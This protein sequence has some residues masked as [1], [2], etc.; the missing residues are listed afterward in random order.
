MMTAA[1]VS[2]K[3]RTARRA[4]CARSRAGLLALNAEPAKHKPGSSE[5]P[6]Q[7]G[8]LEDRQRAR[9]GCRRRPLHPAKSRRRATTRPPSYRR[10]AGARRRAIGRRAA[11]ASVKSSSD[12]ADCSVPCG[13]ALPVSVVAR[14]TRCCFRPAARIEVARAKRRTYA[15][16]A[17][18]AAGAPLPP[19]SSLGTS[20]NPRRGH[21]RAAARCRRPPSLTRDA[22]GVPRRPAA[23]QQGDAL[24]GR[25]ADDRGDRDGDAPRRRRRPRP[26]AARPDRRA[27]ARRPAD[28]RGAR[29]RR[30]RPG[31]APRLAAGAA[32]QG[33]PPP[34][35]RDGRL[36]VGAA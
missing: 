28:P 30:G 3:S 5:E 23:A 18:L 16:R 21:V 2:V 34:R 35:G 6:L 7:T 19:R 17:G 36:G 24:P 22:A 12:G 20:P 33:R 9:R 27:V 32:R 14:T 10:G 26:P 4:H 31:P 1:Q 29:A 11:P 13:W 8:R 15:R 25:P